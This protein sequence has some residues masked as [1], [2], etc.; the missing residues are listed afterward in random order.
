MA[1]DHDVFGWTGIDSLDGVFLAVG[2][3]ARLV[4][5]L[6][7]DLALSR[8]G[9]DLDLSVLVLMREVRHYAGTV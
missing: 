5:I 8:L 1:R 9:V 2:Y 4:Y 3:L 6:M 7:A